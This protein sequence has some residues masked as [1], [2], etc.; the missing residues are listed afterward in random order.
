MPEH[1]TVPIDKLSR[2]LVFLEENAATAQLYYDQIETAEIHLRSD[3]ITGK[4]QLP[5]TPAVKDA[6]KQLIEIVLSESN[7]AY[8]AGMSQL[9]DAV[10]NIVDTR[11]GVIE[12]GTYPAPENGAT[13]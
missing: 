4:V 13:L 3:Y 2:Q 5:N 8:L 10:A 7:H 9:K 1:W 6:I 12:I 11:I